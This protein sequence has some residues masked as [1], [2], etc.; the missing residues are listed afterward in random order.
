MARR[1]VR[2]GMYYASKLGMNNGDYAFIAFQLNPND[3]QRFIK[4]PEL[5]FYGEYPTTNTLDEREQKELYNA[6][7]SMLLL[8]FNTRQI[9]KYDKFVVEMKHR[10]SDPPFCS[11]VY[12]GV[13]KYGNITIYYFNRTVS[14]FGSCS[15]G[16]R[17]IVYFGYYEGLSEWSGAR[18]LYLQAMAG[19][20]CSQA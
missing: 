18:C 12:K 4:Q 14:E 20:D 5:W 11:D 3:V 2:E 13:I 15:L 7:R 8:V 19:F 16:I 1:L 17:P 10:M 9:D 6:Y